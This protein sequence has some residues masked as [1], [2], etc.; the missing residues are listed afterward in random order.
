MNAISADVAILRANWGTVQ[1]GW[2]VALSNARAFIAHR[3]VIVKTTVGA[4]LVLSTRLRLIGDTQT[5]VLR[6]WLDTTPLKDVIAATDAH[7]RAVDVAMDGWQVALAM[8]RLLLLAFTAAGALI[9]AAD[10]V[11]RLALTSP[12][13]W[14]GVLLDSPLLWSAIGLPVLGGLARAILRWRLRVLLAR[15]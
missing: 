9:G 12:T 5:D 11:V 8:E 4:Q 1:G 14:L 3:R 10:V 13:Q 6:S 15:A 7:F 2:K